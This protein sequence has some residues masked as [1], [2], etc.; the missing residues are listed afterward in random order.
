M[1]Q[2]ASVDMDMWN[3]RYQYRI[4]GTFDDGAKEFVD[5]YDGRAR[6]EENQRY[7]L[8]RSRFSCPVRIRGCRKT[9]PSINQNAD[10]PCKIPRWPSGFRFPGSS[11]RTD[12]SLVNLYRDKREEQNLS[13]LMTTPVPDR[14][15]S[16]IAA[17]NGT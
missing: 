11:L 17:A 9:S 14:R 2:S 8:H 7:D 6:E 16:G 15:T 1:A 10:S 4:F 12:S 5:G 13:G 3:M